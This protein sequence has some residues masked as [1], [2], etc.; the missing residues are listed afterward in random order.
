MS[1]KICPQCGTKYAAEHRF[2]TLDGAS[3]VSEHPDDSLL[4]RIIADRYHVTQKLGEGGM[5]E[6]Y[7]AEHVRIR[8]KVAVKIMRRWMAEDHVALGRFHREAENASQISHPNVATIYDF[9]ETSDGIVYFAM[10][11][12]DGRPLTSLLEKE[13]R[14]G[15]VRSLDIV[16]QTADALSAAHHLGI[17][18]RDL[19]PDNVMVGTG[20]AGTDQVKLVDFGI[21]RVMTR[22]TQQFTSTGMIVGTPDYMSP[23]QLSGDSMDVRTDLYALALIAYRML[24]GGEAFGKGSPHET[25]MWRLTR[26]PRPLRELC[27]EVE[28]PVA[29]QALFERALAAAPESRFSEAIEFAN[30]LDQALTQVPLTAADDAYLQALAMRSATPPRGFGT[31]EGTLT[32]PRAHVTIDLPTPPPRTAAPLPEPQRSVTAQRLA[33]SSDATE[34]RPTVRD[35]ADEDTVKVVSVDAPTLPVHAVAA[36]PTRRRRRAGLY[37][38]AGGAVVLAAALAMIRARGNAD[39]ITTLPPDSAAAAVAATP[40]DTAGAGDSTLAAST[41]AVM[42]RD[43]ITRRYGNGV[44]AVSSRTGHGAGFLVDSSGLV[45]TVARLASSEA[46]EVQVDGDRKYRAPVVQREGSLAIVLLPPRACSRCPVLP[47][48]G[49]SVAPQQGDS[50]VAIGSPQHAASTRSRIGTLTKVGGARLSWS[51]SIDARQVGTPLISTLGMVVGVAGV[52]GTGGKEV[53]VPAPAARALLIAV[54]SKPVTVKPDTTLLPT[55]PVK[56][57]IDKDRTAA[58]RNEVDD[59]YRANNDGFAVLVM[60][61]R[62]VAWRRTSTDTSRA[63]DDP[64]AIEKTFKS[65]SGGLGDPIRKWSEWDEYWNE[66]RAVVVIEVAPDA[67]KPPFHGSERPIEFR[68]G[69]V[70]SIVLKRDGATVPAIETA[71]VAAVPDTAQYGSRP[72]FRSGIAV[73]AP[74]AFADGNRFALDVTD[75]A[76]PGASITIQIPQ[77]TVNAIRNELGPYLSR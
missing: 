43:A 45:L 70:A 60:T 17:L 30:A 54:Q 36:D 59:T 44:F 57:V 16:R 63:S 76:R 71:S 28:W 18:H 12:V 39:A 32:P 66:R 58:S 77:K 50:A 25:L 68:R 56:L 15:V 73:F 4:G 1:A 55:W 10:E 46:V 3:L 75:R 38:A 9:G 67:A 69:D 21:S 13:G 48:A 72:F 62:V 49:D 20:R 22:G 33:V 35:T 19:K 42:G 51:N 47:L 40:S 65:G 24:S 61:P 14:L 34:D 2:C 37:V 31:V 29:A 6:V 64:F 7:L 23:E 52:A 27:P 41:P 11:Y 53:F 8:R 26:P 5:G 74:S